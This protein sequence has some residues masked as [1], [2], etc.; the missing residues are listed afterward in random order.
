MSSSNLLLFSLAL[1]I[2][3]LFLKP[4]IAYASLEEAN[5]LLKW[6]E[7]LEIPNNSLLSSWLPLPMKSSASVPCTSWFGVV[8][9]IDWSIHRLNLCS[10]GLKGTLHQF[11][12]SLLHNLTYFDLGMNNFFGPIPPE[13]RLLSKLVYLDFSENKFSGVIPSEIGNLHHLTIFYLDSNNISGS[14]P[15]SLSDLISLKVLYLDQNQLSGPIPIEL[16][17]LKHLTDL[18]LNTNQLSGSI[19]SSLELEVSH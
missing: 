16:E 1:L 15:S 10:S 6:K 8:C 7:S 11:P 13:I 5:A 14:I 2:I 3:P 9:N 19:P 4:N 17:N 12:F 18:A